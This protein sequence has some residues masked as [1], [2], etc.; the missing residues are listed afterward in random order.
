MRAAALLLACMAPALAGNLTRYVNPLLATRGGGGFGG[1]GCQARNPGAMAPHPLVRLG[2]DT[3]R[4]DPVL[5]EAWSKLNRH[6][7]YFGSDT[8]IRAFSHT[9]VQGAGD[10]DLGTLGVMVT[11]GTAA[12]VAAAAAVRPLVLPFPPLT[13]DRSPFAAPFTHGDERASPGYYAVGL[14]TLD[15]TAELTVGGPRTGM[16]RYTCR[17]AGN[18]TAPCTIVLNVCHRAHGGACGSAS[19]VSATVAGS[20]SAVV[21]GVAQDEGEF[22]RFNYTGLSFFFS[23]RIEARDAAGASVPLAAAGTWAAYAAQPLPGPTGNASVG[24]DKDSLGVYLSFAPAAGAA[25]VVTV[26]VGLSAVSLAGA[27]ANLVAELGDGAGGFVAFEAAAA[28]AEAEW[29]A[30]LGALAVTL[31]ADAAGGATD[32][33]AL[34]AGPAG[35]AGAGAG[36]GAHV[37]AEARRALAQHLATPEGAATALVEG[38][39]QLL[40][41]GAVAGV[42][43]AA[44]AANQRSAPAAARAHLQRLPAPTLDV[45]AATRALQQGA[46]ASHALA[47]T[48]RATAAGSDLDAFYTLAYLSLCA[49]TTYS[50]ADGT[51]LGFDFAQHPADAPGTRFMSDLSLW[52]TY[53][54]QAVFLALVAPRALADESASLLAMGRQGSRGM[55]RWPFANLYTMDMTGH[56]GVP[57]LADCVVHTGACA[58][59]VGVGEAAAAAAAAIAAQDA[60]VPLYNSPGGYADWPANP[61]SLT[62]ELALDDFAAALLAGAAGDA[63]G[64]AAFGARAG[65]WRSV[66]DA[67]IPTTPPRR[68]N[69]SFITDRSI[70][71]PHPGNAY[72]TEGNAAQWMW[73]VPHNMSALAAAFPGG[74]EEYSAILTEVLFNQTYWTSALSTFLPNPYCWLGNEP[75][76]LLP[77]SHAWGGAA[78]APEAAYWPRWHLRTYYLPTQDMIPGNDDYGALSSWGVFAYLGLYPVSPTGTFALGSPVFAQARVAAPM[79]PYS[80][81]P[82][83]ALRILAHNASAARIYVSG[84][85]ANVVALGAPL[86]TWQQLWPE[87]VQEA[88]L[89]FDMVDQPVAWGA[90]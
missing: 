65:N 44:R 60:L 47:A 62:V 37:S 14:P 72:F 39:S 16:H 3:T 31:P 15:A 4:F 45:Q 86:V 85:R 28:A 84:A 34:G 5:G 24:A 27:R 41:V 80:G 88:L 77:W 79:G 53:R 8:H 36:A 69:G 74:A 17:A 20:G 81:A 87:G 26:R 29:E 1:W 48:A 51:Y 32:E 19:A 52:D 55:P 25:V 9:H 43:A 70:Y 71:A 61:A 63:A 68:A 13:L 75:S 90:Y 18:G 21:E 59:R 82:P 67:A 35:R 49:P 64:A 38:W 56:H 89:E 30:A 6:A 78:R 33:A 57:M 42:L 22:V 10:A 11:R 46:A 12:A 83:L 58:G 40:P 7:G 54:S 73:A 2:P 23:A 50:D 66:F 76:M